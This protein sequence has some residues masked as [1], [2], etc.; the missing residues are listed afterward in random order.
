MNK[1]EQKISNATCEHLNRMGDGWHF[2]YCGGNTEVARGFLGASR[3]R[4]TMRVRLYDTDVVRATGAPHD[5]E[6]D[7]DLSYFSHTT[8][9]RVN[10]A[11][12]GLG[13]GVRVRKMKGDPA[14]FV[15]GK[16]V[17]TS[18]APSFRVKGGEVQS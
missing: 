4:P 6:L 14:V 5:Y 7:I 2:T 18:Y 15:D 9:S 10:A 3:H 11:L 8:I 13:V 16:L 12:D 17:S 1:I